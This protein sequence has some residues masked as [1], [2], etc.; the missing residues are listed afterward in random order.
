MNCSILLKE[1]VNCS[2]LR[3]HKNIYCT[4][5]I[6]KL[7]EDNYKKDKTVCKNCYKKKRKYYIK[8][9]EKDSFS[10]LINSRTPNVGASF[11]G[12]THLLPKIF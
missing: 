4:A 7:D 8:I 10:G 11:S 3:M 1:R 2:V 6:I 12:K 5:R 9:S